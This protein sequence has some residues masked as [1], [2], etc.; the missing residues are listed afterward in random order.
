MFPRVFFAAHFFA[1]RFFPQSAGV[2]VTPFRTL[3]LM[4]S[5]PAR[6]LTGSLASHSLT[7]SLSST[8][9]KGN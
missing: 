9:L 5:L 7:G 4:G 3:A 2:V 6:S 8:P 1:P